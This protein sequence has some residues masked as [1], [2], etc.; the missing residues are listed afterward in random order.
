VVLED[1]A[2]SI[3][4]SFHGRATGT[5]GDL[6]ATSFYPT[7]NL[8]AFGDGGA[9]LV[10]DDSNAWEA[11]ALR[12]YGQTAKYH[13]DLCGYNSRLDEL[14]AALLHRVFLP[15][16]P[17]WTERRREIAAAYLRGIRNP[18]VHPIGAREGADP[19]WHLFPVL[20]RPERK[21]A[22][23]SHLKSRGVSSGEHYPVPIHEQKA[24][25]GVA[26]E[27]GDACEVAMRICASEVSLPIHA[28]LSDA[29]VS[30]VIEA[31]NEWCV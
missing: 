11:R 9:I 19:C 24:L 27:M 20:V 21:D 17:R 2:Q 31:V 30:Q 22:F 14:Q 10:N 7:K 29:E 26:F 8:G 15:C 13:H 25:L 3:G 28:Y 1:C 23:M 18:E 4:A 12:D 5:V 16:L 6:A